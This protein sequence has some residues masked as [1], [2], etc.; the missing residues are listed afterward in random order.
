MYDFK[1]TKS[2]RRN[3]WG[4]TRSLQYQSQ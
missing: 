1:S 3:P 2:S 4:L